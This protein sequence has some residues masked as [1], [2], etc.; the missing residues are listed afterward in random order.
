MPKP[1]NNKVSVVVAHV[2]TPVHAHGITYG[3]VYGAVH[4]E[5]EGILV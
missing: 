4:D 3:V 5:L 2:L 1:W